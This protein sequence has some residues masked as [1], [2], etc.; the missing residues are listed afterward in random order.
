M[1]KTDTFF[2]IHNYNSDP[3]ELLEYCKDYLII[4]CSDDSKTPDIL[5]SSGYNYITLP[6]TGQNIT[7]YFHFFIDNYDSLP[8][9][10]ALLKGHIIGRHVSKDYFDRVYDNKWFTYLYQEQNMWAKYGKGGDEN[11]IASLLS[12]DGYLELNNSW[13]MNQNHEYRYFY[14]IDDFY[15][16]VYTDPVIPRYCTFSPGG[17]YIVSREQILKNSKTFY[18]NLNKLMEYKK[19]VNFPAEAFLI[20]RLLP[21]IFTSR[22]KTNPWM[23]DEEEFDDML[24]KCEESVNLYREWN[25]LHLK[26]FRIMLGAKEPIFLQPDDQTSKNSCHLCK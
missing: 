3:K 12:E 5:K 4:D 23:E 8:D 19:E 13:Y 1:N 2:L 17:C 25:S 9:H 15:R 7:S 14:N 26:R 20:E 18:K 11:S 24:T 16:F 21:W 22:L 6:N 10:I